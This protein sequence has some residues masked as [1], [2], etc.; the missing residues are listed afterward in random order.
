MSTVKKRGLNLD[1]SLGALLNDSAKLDAY[2]SKAGA[3]FVDVE[4]NT[5]LPGRFQ[6]R[7]NIAQE[8]LAQLADSI[9]S[10]GIL[11]PIVVKLGSA[12]NT[13]E[14][15]AGERRW[16]AAKLAQLK[17]VPVVVKD[18]TDQ[19]AFAIALIENIQREQLNAL[20]EAG[21]YERL[22]HD[23]GLSHEKIAQFV[24]RS[25]SSISNSLRLLAL[26]SDVKL[27]LEKNQIDVGH[28]KVLL[29]LSAANQQAVAREIIAKQLS[30]R[31]TETLVAKLHSKSLPK[32]KPST[33]ADV[34]ALENKLSK[35]LASVV[36][37]LHSAKG[38]GRIVIKYNSLDELDGIL[39][40]LKQDA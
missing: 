14:I 20:E 37:I 3:Q 10:Q 16:R 21:A 32:R 31:A 23:F 15:I 25:R 9:R 13:Y 19:D 11:Q 5:L 7:K 24:G 18:V 33:D 12:K 6:P 22:I 34:R 30:V 35:Q 28:A 8:E 4:I 26:K 38:S 2:D 27:M 39:A 36:K 29:P 40:H 1:R 17:S